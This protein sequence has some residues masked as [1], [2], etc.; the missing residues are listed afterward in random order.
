MMDSLQDV[1]RALASIV[2]VF[3]WKKGE[4]TCNKTPVFIL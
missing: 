3:L 1:I 2:L 4:L